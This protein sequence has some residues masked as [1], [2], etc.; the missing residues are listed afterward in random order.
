[1]NDDETFGVINSLPLAAGDLY[2]ALKDV[3]RYCVRV[4]GMPDK[5]KG[6]T[7]EQQ[8]AMDKAHAALAK[9]EG[10]RI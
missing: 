3:L 7:L 5:N 6:R 4:K 9:A 2:A 1:M 10:R 8:A